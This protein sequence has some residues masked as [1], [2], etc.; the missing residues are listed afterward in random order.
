MRKDQVNLKKQFR[1]LNKSLQ[2]ANRQIKHREHVVEYLNEE[3]KDLQQEVLIA[4]IEHYRLLQ[5]LP[6][7]TQRYFSI[8]GLQREMWAMSLWK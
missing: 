7:L 1:K 2:L 4:R 8:N 5:G 3:V 6:A